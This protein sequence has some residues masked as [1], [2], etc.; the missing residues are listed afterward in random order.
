MVDIF[1]DDA[2]DGNQNFEMDN[3]FVEF[4]SDVEHENWEKWG[5]LM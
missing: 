2:E 3:L 1:Q 4:E 5:N